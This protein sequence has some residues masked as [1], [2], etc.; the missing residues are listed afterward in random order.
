MKPEPIGLERDTLRAPQEVDLDRRL[1]VGQH[2][3]DVD[4]GLRDPGRAAQREEPLL[5]LVPGDRLTRVVPGHHRAHAGRGLARGVP[6]ELILERLQVEHV[7]DLGLVERLLHAAA[8]DHAGQVELGPGH[9]GAGDVL[10][11]R[12][13]VGLECGRAVHVETLMAAV[14]PA[15][16]GDVDERAAARAQA[17]QRRGRAVRE[18][19]ARAARQHGGHPAPVTPQ[20]GWR[21]E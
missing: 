19:G 14:C 1:A 15:R 6:L 13:V 16:N 2:Q 17:E 12:R 8:V 5:E 18:Y 10:G 9:G 3:P 4:L 21:D 11:R 7:E 20:Q